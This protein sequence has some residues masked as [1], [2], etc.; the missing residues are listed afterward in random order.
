MTRRV[1]AGCLS[2][3]AWAEPRFDVATI[4]AVSS[5]EPGGFHHEMTPGGLTMRAVSLGYCVRLAFGLTVQRPW[6]LAGPSWMDPPTEALFDV[7]AK[8]GSPSKPDEIRTMLQALLVERL[9][10]A[11][12]W[13][14]RRLPAYFLVA[15]SGSP[16][17]R[18]S[19]AAE[20]KVRTGSKPFE[21]ICEGLT[22]ADLALQLGPPMTTRPVVD[23][24]DF[25]GSFD[26]TLDLSPYIVD[27]ATDVERAAFRAVRE[28]LGLDL[29][30]GRASFRVLVVDHAERRPVER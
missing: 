22:M 28:Q 21:L 3:I 10:L 5:P 23:R 7:I 29:R 15:R 19:A 8:T 25:T 2:A 30:P 17:L 24:T 9:R 12:H 27:P 20:R 13:E 11:T 6:E 4:K 1:F 18:P 16:R 14:G 26:L